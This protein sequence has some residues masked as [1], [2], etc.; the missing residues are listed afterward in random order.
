LSRN[1]RVCNSV[2]IGLDPGILS[3]YPLPEILRFAQNDKVGVLDSR[4]RG[5]DGVIVLDS[6]L[7]GNDG[8]IVLDSRLRGNDGMRVLDSR[9]RIEYGAGYA[10]MTRRGKGR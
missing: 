3:T 6:R 7:R 4:L 10:G 1:P 2:I 8:V 9:P 5:N